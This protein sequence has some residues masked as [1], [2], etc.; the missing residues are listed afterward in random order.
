[1]MASS[2]MVSCLY[3]GGVNFVPELFK[4]FKLRH[5]CTVSICYSCGS[6]TWHNGVDPSSEIWTKVGGDKGGTTFKMTFQ[7]AIVPDQTA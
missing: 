2:S 7:I 6:F 1:M 3:S 4:Q 5:T